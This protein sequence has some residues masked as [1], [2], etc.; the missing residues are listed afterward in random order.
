[1]G[2]F[3]K[4]PV[5]PA[6]PRPTGDGAPANP[7]WVRPRRFSLYFFLAR[8]RCDRATAWAPSPIAADIRLVDPLLTSPAAKRPGMIVS[9]GRG[10]RARGHREGSRRARAP[11][12]R[13]YTERSC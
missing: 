10:S 9:R 12:V 2:G 7:G 13:M 5:T 8:K 3:G 6:T 1:M 4:Y 11:P